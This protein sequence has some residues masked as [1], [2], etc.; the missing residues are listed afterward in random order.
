MYSRH[1]VEIVV[2]STSS[3]EAR[4]SRDHFYVSGHSLNVA[5]RDEYLSVH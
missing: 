2:L 5:E 4:T 3:N 1:L